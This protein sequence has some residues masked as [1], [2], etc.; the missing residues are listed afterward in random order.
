M[1]FQAQFGSPRETIGGAV[2]QTA[3]TISNTQLQIGDF[4]V[5]AGNPI[6]WGA[7]VVVILLLFWVMKR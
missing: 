4:T 3:R 5:D 6:V 1:S 7:G 2:S